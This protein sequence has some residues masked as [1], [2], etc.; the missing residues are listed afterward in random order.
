MSSEF[1][2]QSPEP[3]TEQIVQRQRATGA[4][5][6]VIRPEMGALTL[7]EVADGLELFAAE[8]LPVVHK[9]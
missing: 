6:L 1:R 9:L 7:N 2:V 8:V 3:I 5:V 4:G